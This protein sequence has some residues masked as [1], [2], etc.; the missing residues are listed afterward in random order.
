MQNFKTLGKIRD[1]HG[2]KGE[3]FLI[4]FSKKFEWLEDMDTAYLSRREQ[5]E[6]GNWI[7]KLHQFPIKRK[8]AH[9]VGHILKL[10]GMETR[11]D[12]ES[13]KGATFQVPSTVLEV[14]RKDGSIYATQ[15]E[16]FTVQF[17]GQTAVGVIVG[18]GSN[19][20]QDLLKIEW[21][22]KIV[23]I[24]YVDAFVKSVDLAAKTIQ[25]NVPEGLLFIEDL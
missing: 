2:I 12:A 22:A 5:D 11:N 7:E 16:G 3:V 6:E 13:F 14:P 17:E 21:N 8:K 1:A 24:P 15:L 4:S 23:E 25:L 19:T 18:I 20:A 10:E 9:K